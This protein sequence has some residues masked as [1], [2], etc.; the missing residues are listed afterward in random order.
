MKKI[1]VLLVTLSF[2]FTLSAC[3]TADLDN[4]KS[5]LNSEAL[6]SRESLATLSYLSGSLID[7][8]SDEPVVGYVPTKLSDNGEEETEIE[9]E[10]D[11]VNEYMD[12]LQELMD[13]GTDAFGS[14]IEGISDNPL[15]A[16]MITFNVNEEV[17]T[18]YYNI[19]IM[20]LELSGILVIG[21]VEY[22]IE[23][24]NTLLD[25]DDLDEED[26]LD[27]EEDPNT[28]SEDLDDDDNDSE[29][30]NQDDEQKMVLTAYNGDNFVQVTYKIETDDEETETKFTLVSYIDGIEKEVFMKISI[31]DDEYKIT[32]EE[33]GNEFTFKREVEDG[34]TTYKLKYK[35]NGVEGEVKIIETI[36]ELGETVYTYKITEGDVFKDLEKD[37]PG[38][39]S[40]DDEDDENEQEN[41]DEQEDADQ[42]DEDNQDGDNQDGE[43][44][45]QLPIFTIDELSNYT[46]ID[47]T[48]A[49]I[50]VDGIVY[51]VTDEFDNGQHQGIQIGG[52]DATDIFASSPHIELFL[53]S[54]EI[55]GTLEEYEEEID[56]I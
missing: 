18:I 27:D 2:V 4:L 23:V 26:E 5:V 31:E 42:E 30:G 43:T 37:E 35:V 17:Y 55:V 20:T 29:E 1:L 8:E 24:T 12:R 15:Y 13:N 11:I 56:G 32:I 48:T 16:L 46:G 50:A 47:G 9:T 38:H 21:D 53:T 3:T 14:A 39:H 34:E 28:D 54:L 6:S 7:L 25:N 22:V 19:D 40:D 51:D 44:Q 33:E 49:Y 36:N 45:T 52:T 41:E 10:L